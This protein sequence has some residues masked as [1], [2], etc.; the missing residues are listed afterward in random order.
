MPSVTDNPLKSPY[1]YI[2]IKVNQLKISL[3][4]SNGKISSTDSNH[5]YFSKDSNIN[6]IADSYWK[7]LVE[8]LQRECDN[9]EVI[10][11]DLHRKINQISSTKSNYQTDTDKII[12]YNE[13]KILVLKDQIENQ[14][15]MLKISDK[16][17]EDGQ[18]EINKLQSDSQKDKEEIKFYKSEIQNF[19]L[20]LDNNTIDMVNK[21]TEI[22]KL[23]N[24]LLNDK[25]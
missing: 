13:D 24:K 17:I 18:I 6:I 8:E 12:Q 16:I 15:M 19:K 10:I 7:E 9:K 20:I 23:R 25:K 22:L 14:N 3:G 5:T 21:D 2:H 11:N 1:S 4:L